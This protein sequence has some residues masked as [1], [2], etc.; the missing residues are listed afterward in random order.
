MP[1]S[2][3]PQATF[4]G[5]LS[6]QFQQAREQAQASF[7]AASSEIQKL[8]LDEKVSRLAGEV[9][10]GLNQAAAGIDQATSEFNRAAGAIQSRVSEVTGTL[11]SVAGSTSNIAADIS[12]GLEKLGAGSLA[13]GLQSFAG[14]VSKTAGMLNNIL[15]LTRG[16]NLPAGAEIF[17]AR[18]ESLK[19][20]PNPQ[21]DWRV[22]VNCNWSIFGSNKM[23]E[24]LKS[25]NGAVFPLTPDVN[26][27]TSAS[28]SAIDPTHSV[29]P[30]QAYKNSTVSGI[31]IGGEFPVET[32]SDA[33]YWLAT[34]T[35]FKT[36]TKMFFGQGANAGNPP[37]ICIL[38]G[39]GPGILPNVPVVISSFSIDL[40]TDSDYIKCEVFG[41]PTWVPALSRINITA[42]PIYSR[43]RLRQFSLQEYARGSLVSRDG[44]GFM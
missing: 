20:E 37:I 10:S 12:G 18:G 1:L 34:T 4:V 9:N 39:Y 44:I 23:F 19:V 41:K 8:K 30:I 25:T 7:V 13:G 27:S 38:S 17:S 36:A 15:S 3:N 16:A 42:V 40:G 29:Y 35:F 33:A 11:Q 14:A 31:E 5:Q 21:N 32:Q 26:F 24:L 43:S 6:T 28:Y 22:R 2:I